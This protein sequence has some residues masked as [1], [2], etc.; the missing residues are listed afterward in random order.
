MDA[1]SAIYLILEPDV[2]VAEDLS[3]TIS[4]GDPRAET[5]VVADIEAAGAALDGLPPV[6]A[7]VLN[8]RIADL[9]RSGLAERIEGG[10]GMIVV[11]NGQEDPADIAR[12]GWQFVQRPF[13]ADSVVSA[14]ATART[15]MMPFR[16]SA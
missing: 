2:V 5:H 9:E 16:R 7:A 14:L 13:R 4:A 3:D 1:G 12:T 8:A 11:L 10:G 15:R 6:E